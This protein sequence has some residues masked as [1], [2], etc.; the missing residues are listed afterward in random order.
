M[1]VRVPWQKEQVDI[2]DWLRRTMATVF[3][4]EG[5]SPFWL[6]YQRDLGVDLLAKVKSIDDL[7]LF[8]AP[9]TVTGA[10][11]EALTRRPLEEYIP[12]SIIKKGK[13]KLITSVTGGTTGPEKTVVY[14]T[15][16]TWHS[17]GIHAYYFLTLHGWLT[18][19]DMA[20]VLYIGPT[21]NHILGK[22]IMKM[23]EANNGFFF[24]I[25]LD[26]RIIKKYIAEGAMTS[27]DRYKEHIFEQTAQVLRSQRV[28]V[29]VTTSKLL[30]DLAER[31]DLSG[32]RAI[33]HGGTAVSP[34]DYRVMQEELFRGTLL[35]GTYGNALFGSAFEIPREDSVFDLTYY[36]NYP[37]ILLEVVEPDRPTHRV[38]YGERGR[39]LFRRLTP[40]IFIPAFL[41][42]DEALRQP[43]SERFRLPFDGIRN[44]GIFEKMRTTTI[45]GVY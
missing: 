38:G 11:T 30:L 44:P 17:A 12:R 24:T 42:R 43:P 41:E 16:T 4:P 45:E 32:I 15:D 31:F 29:L 1:T 21:G 27:L 39:V 19:A 34:D 6:E 8:G 2:D 35:I 33:L 13:A 23:A 3:D 37:R 36:A 5:G 14:E 26:P 28:T 9:E 10:I 7:A 25:D 40:E 22:S 18:P 20:N